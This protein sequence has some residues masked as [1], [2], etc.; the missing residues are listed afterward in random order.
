[1]TPTTPADFIGRTR[2]IAT[3]LFKKTAQF[4]TEKLPAIERRYL[5]TGEAGTG[6]TSLAMALAAFA[7]GNTV[8]SI[9]AK[10]SLNV[11]WVNGQSWTVDLVRDWAMAGHYL[12]MYGNRIVKIVDEIDS[13]SNAT[14]NESLSYLDALP[15]HVLLIATT[16]K[17]VKELPER[18]Q[19]RFKVHTFT[20]VPAADLNAWLSASFPKLEAGWAQKIAQSVGGNVRAAMLDALQRIEYVEAM[21]TV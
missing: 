5:F 8:E 10:S 7:T 21:A 1:M 15:S 4:K 14:A 19:S 3:V 12:P 18:L 6:K 20:A 16:N 2:T 13:I 9:L 17:P 11:D